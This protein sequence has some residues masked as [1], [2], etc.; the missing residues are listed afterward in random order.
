[1][2]WHLLILVAFSG[3][4]LPQPFLFIVATAR[5]VREIEFTQTQPLRIENDAGSKCDYDWQTVAEASS[6]LARYLEFSNHQRPHQ[7]L[8]YRTP[9]EAYGACKSLVEACV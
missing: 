2:A 8:S 7:A 6:G 4:Y 3:V 5:R 1:M 9:A